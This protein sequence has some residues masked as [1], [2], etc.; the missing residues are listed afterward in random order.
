M[1]LSSLLLVLAAPLYAQDDAR[2][3]PGGLAEQGA[4]P[5]ELKVN[6][7]DG[8]TYV[9]IPPGKFTMGCSAG[10]VE[11]FSDEKPAHEVQI[12]KGFWLGQTA[13]TV[14]AWKRCTQQTRTSM[15]P[16]KTGSG[17]VPNP[18][19]SDEQ[20]PIVNVTWQQASGY[21]GWMGGRLP[22]EAEWEYAARA[23]TT[24]ARYGELEAI[25][26]YAD[27]SGKQRID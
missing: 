14:G 12:T 17:Q 7:Q 2:R 26:W 24:G 4:L 27:N 16:E 11:C 8:L 3:I 22:T 18:G 25:A 1:K 5:G 20:Q 21:C 23:G 10:D 13:T 19:W 15:P 6:P 9:W